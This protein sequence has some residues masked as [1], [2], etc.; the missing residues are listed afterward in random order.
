[1]LMED[2]VLILKYEKIDDALKYVCENSFY[3]SNYKN[4][5]VV[6]GKNKELTETIA[7]KLSDEHIMLT[8][9]AKSFGAI[10]KD[11]NIF[12]TLIKND[13]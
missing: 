13:V 8:D 9:R 5:Y 4:E 2:R 6:I 12:V 11:D 1:M 7:S 10:N 3:T